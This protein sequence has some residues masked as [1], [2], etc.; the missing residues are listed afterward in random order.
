M[1]KI[2]ALL[3]VA[4]LAAALVN[5]GMAEGDPIKIGCIQDTSGGASIAGQPNEWGVKYAVQYLN[6]NGGINGRMIEL[7]CRDCQNDTEVGVTCYRELVD[8]IEVDAIIGPPLSN[9]ASAWVELATEDEIPIVGHFMDEVCTTDPDT[10]EPYPYMFLAEPS[11]SVQSYILGEYA[12]K[13]LGVKSVATLFNTSNAYAVAHERPFVG[14]ISANGGEVLAEETFTWSDTDYSAQAMKI[15]QLKP[16]AVLLCD[17]CN[18]MVTAYDNLREAGFEGY[19]LGANTMYP[20]FNTLIK[21]KLYNCYFV[22]NYDL[23]SGDIADLLAI[24]MKDTGTDYPT[25]NVGF[26]W[27]ATMVLAN[28]M[29]QAEDPTNGPEVREILENNTVE[30]PSIGGAKITIDPAN[31]RPTRDMGMYI[32]TYDDKNEV[33]CL[34]YMTTDYVAE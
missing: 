3:L 6:D 10:G 31:H 17:Y 4:I 1:R 14:Y 28:A 23:R 8:E 2:L 7:Y 13:E 11:C 32:A 21:N 9:P 19:I 29:K 27:D 33:D 25:S 24:Q 12:M 15:A 22:Q 30:V 34:V 20:P 16:D 26:G 5:C 18:Q